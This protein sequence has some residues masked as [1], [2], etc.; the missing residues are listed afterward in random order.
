[1]SVESGHDILFLDTLLRYYLHVD[2]RTL[3]D[4]EW[5]YSIKYLIDIRKIER[6]SS[7]G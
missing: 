2:P 6:E 7:N 5:A 3:C 1:M 4:E